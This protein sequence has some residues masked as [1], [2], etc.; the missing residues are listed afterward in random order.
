MEL[1]CICLSSRR[2]VHRGS[3]FTLEAL[4]AEQG[5]SLLI[6]F[7]SESAPTFVLVD[8]GP[9]SV[10]YNQVLLPQL[11]ELRARFQPAAALAMAL[12]VCSHIDNDHIAGI[13]VLVVGVGP[14]LA[15]TVAIDCSWR[16]SFRRLAP[17]LTEGG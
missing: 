11:K 4:Q 3:I 15:D 13:I 1:T 9:G 14:A 5:D 2:K 7:G 10:A 16:N 8:G 17:N 12:I 6:Q